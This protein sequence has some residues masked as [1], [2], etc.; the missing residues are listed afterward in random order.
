MAAGGSL[1][2]SLSGSTPASLHKAITSIATPPD[3]ISDDIKCDL[4]C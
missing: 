1:R 4:K 3:V 2:S